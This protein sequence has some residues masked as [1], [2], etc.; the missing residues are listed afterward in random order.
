MQNEFTVLVVDKA[1][2]IEALFVTPQF[3]L[4][5]VL[6]VYELFPFKLELHAMFFVYSA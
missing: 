5:T 2:C 3:M 1:D 4:I 6:R